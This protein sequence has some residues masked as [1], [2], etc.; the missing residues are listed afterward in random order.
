MELFCLG[1]SSGL[2]FTDKV[3]TFSNSVLEHRPSILGKANHPFRLMKGDFPQKLVAVMLA[4]ASTLQF[5][6][7]L[8]LD[9]QLEFDDENKE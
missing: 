2:T 3:L 6:I 9:S 5:C 8:L 7:N 4:E 1:Q